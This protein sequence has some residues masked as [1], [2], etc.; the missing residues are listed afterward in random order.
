VRLSDNLGFRL[1]NIRTEVPN[2]DD[3]FL[4]LTGRELRE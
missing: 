2:M 4:T 1:A 3:V